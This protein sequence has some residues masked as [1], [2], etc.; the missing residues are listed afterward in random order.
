MRRAD[1]EPAVL[2]DPEHWLARAEEARGLVPSLLDEIDRQLLRKIAE[3]YE[4][5]AAYAARRSAN[6]T[7]LLN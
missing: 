1:D 5:L 2:N 3:G 6:S 7:G 4:R